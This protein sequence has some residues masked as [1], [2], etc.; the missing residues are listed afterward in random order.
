MSIEFKRISRQS[1]GDFPQI[2]EVQP[3]IE[4]GT[5]FREAS[6]REGGVPLIRFEVGTV[7]FEP[8]CVGIAVGNDVRDGCGRIGPITTSHE[9]AK[10]ALVEHTGQI[11][12]HI[13]KI[14]RYVIEF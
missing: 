11:P 13:T 3:G 5:I 4:G 6:D 8:R 12:P 2:F 7:F 14:E 10:R 1:P 9:L